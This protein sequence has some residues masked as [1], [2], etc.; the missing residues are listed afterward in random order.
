MMQLS[1]GNRTYSNYCRAF[2]WRILSFVFVFILQS[3]NDVVSLLMFSKYSAPLSCVHDFFCCESICKSYA[4]YQ[5]MPAILG[6]RLHWLRVLKYWSHNYWG[7]TR[8]R[9]MQCRL[10]EKSELRRITFGPL[11][12]LSLNRILKYLHFEQQLLDIPIFFSIYPICPT[13]HL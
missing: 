7:R 11:F 8:T 12:L 3:L 6:N 4:L 1:I 2:P 9:H 5:P 10:D 13:A